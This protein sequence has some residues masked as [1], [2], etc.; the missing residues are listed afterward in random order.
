MASARPSGV[1][2]FYN[3]NGWLFIAPA[4]VLIGLFMVY[5]I[6]WSL[7]MSSQSGRGAMVKFVGFG[8]I[9]RLANDPVFL[10]A[11]T[12]T[13]TFFIIQVP[14]MILLALSLAAVLNMPKLVGRGLFRTA[15][16][17]PCVTSLVA[18][19][20]L[21]K[22][23][24]AEQ[25]VVNSTLEAIGIIASPIPWLTDGFW[26]KVLIILAIT[27]RWTGYNMIFYLSAM[28]NIDK[29]IYEAARID[30]INAWGRF[31]Y[32]TIPLLKPV[33]LFTSVI[34]T[35]GTLQL[36]DEVMN[37]T[38][39]GPSDSTLTLSLYIYNLTFKFIPNLGYAATVSYVIVVLVAMLA[40][41]QFYAAREKD[42]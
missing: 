15:I 41:V 38:Q 30:G 14:I 2:R 25:G 36:F 23:M 3:V 40:F 5:P 17:L 29:S 42:Q 35:I 7:F 9:V 24:F 8:N 26:A 6:L 18:Y 19:S 28:Q 13:V 16:F 4:L 32:I 37:I 39:G 27:W 21:F 20:A 34:S 11:L 10:H 22:G 31:V 12:N 33:I 1:R